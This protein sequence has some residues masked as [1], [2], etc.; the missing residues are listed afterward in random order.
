MRRFTLITIIC[1]VVL[2]A[3]AAVAQL[4]IAGADREP[5]PGPVPGTPYPF[6]SSPTPEPPTP[7]R[8]P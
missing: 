6:P 8:T 1:L 7:S 4:V 5:Y 3:G 2:L